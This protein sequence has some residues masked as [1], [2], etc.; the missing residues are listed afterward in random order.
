MFR[1]RSIQP[2]F[3]SVLMVAVFVVGT[4]P[5]W[6]A[7]PDPVPPGDHL[8]IEEVQVVLDEDANT[9]TLTIKGGAL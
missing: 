9:T 1:Q 3:V 7:K 4:I 5:T 8:T 2:M 6:A